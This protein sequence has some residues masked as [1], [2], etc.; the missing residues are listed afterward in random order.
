MCVCVCVCVCVSHL[1]PLIFWLTLSLLSCL[2]YCKLG[3]ICLFRLEFSL[4]ICSG[5]RSGIAGF[6]GNSIFS[7]LRNLHGGCTNLHF[8]QQCRRLAFSL[9]PL[10]HLLFVGFFSDGHS[11]QCEVIRHCSFDLRLSSSDLIIFSCACWPSVCLLWRN[12]LFGSPVLFLFGFF[13]FLLLSCILFVYFESY[14]STSSVFFL[15]LSVR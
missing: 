9:H 2:G 3:W 8:H 10:Q 4:D 6:C 5:Y 14:R 1:C 15:F 7:F 12:G 11:D 13:V